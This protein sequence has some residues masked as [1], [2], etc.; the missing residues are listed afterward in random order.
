MTDEMVALLET[1]PRLDG[2]DLV[3]WSPRGGALSDATMGKLMRTIHEADQKS[4]GK[5]YVD[6][7]TGEQ[8]V[9]HGLRSAFR[10]WIA[11]RTAFDGDLA[12]IALF[13]K[14][15]SK[16]AQAYNR[17]DQVEKRR[18]MMAAWGD[19]LAGKQPEKVVKLGA[20]A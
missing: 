1:L 19:F 17:A 6:A 11:E 8:A 18:V 12:E 3:F 14:V 10:T 20:R 5:G 9:P 2:S 4:G 15:G 7:K 13:H 16:V